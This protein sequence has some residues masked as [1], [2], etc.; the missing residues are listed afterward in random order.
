MTRR[1]NK[2]SSPHYRKHWRSF[3]KTW[4]EQP[5]RKRK[6]KIK[7]QETKDNLRFDPSIKYLI[8]PIVHNPTFIH[9]MKLRFGRGFSMNEVKKCGISKR[10][11]SSIGIAIDKR[12]R[13]KKNEF[14]ANETRL[15]NYIKKVIIYKKNG[16]DKNGKNKEI[17]PINEKNYLRKKFLS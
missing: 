15:N 10:I 6:R 5:S 17:N 13:S 1:S 12:R 14:V 9:N 16:Q 4:F 8:R 7:R 3:V 11:S 2:I